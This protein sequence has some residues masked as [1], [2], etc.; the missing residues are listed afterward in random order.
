M[1][2]SFIRGVEHHAY[3]NHGIERGWFPADLVELVTFSMETLARNC[4]VQDLPNALE[5][6]RGSLTAEFDSLI[7]QDYAVPLTDREKENLDARIKED[8][9]RITLRHPLSR[10]YKKVL[11]SKAIFEKSANPYE[12]LELLKVIATSQGNLI[13]ILDEFFWYTWTGDTQSAIV[14]EAL[15][16][17]GL[18]AL[19]G[20]HDSAILLLEDL[21]DEGNVSWDSRK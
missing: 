14:G 3:I 12:R 21:M 2:D 17:A 1:F 16:I 15:S 13:S 9:P 11:G 7:P 20:R 8:S 10:S 4:G 5:A 18:E 19:R 6:T